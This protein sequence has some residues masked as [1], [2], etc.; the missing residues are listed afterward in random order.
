MS[1]KILLYTLLK[2][3]GI[4]LVV[5]FLVFRGTFVESDSLGLNLSTGVSLNRNIK[6]EIIKGKKTEV[7][8]M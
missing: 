8:G 5:S 3:I 7:K 6:K 2:Q 1:V 4:F